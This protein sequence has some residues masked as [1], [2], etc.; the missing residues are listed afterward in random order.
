MSYPS[1]VVLENVASSSGAA[2]YEGRV[3]ARAACLKARTVRI[4][5]VLPDGD[6]PLGED[7]TDADGAFSISAPPVEPGTEVYA[8]VAK[9]VLKKNTRHNHRC[10]ADRSD[11]VAFPGSNTGGSVDLTALPVGDGK[12]SS[13]P[14]TGHLWSCQQTFNPDQGGAGT[15]GPWF[16]GDGTWD[17]TKKVTVSGQVDWPE[18]LQVSVSGNTRSISTNDLPFH[19]TGTFPVAQSDDAYQYD[20]NPNSISAQS[21][22]FALPANPEPATSPA[23]VGG[24]VGVMLS[25]TVIFNAFDAAGRDAVANEVQD[26]CGGHPQNRGVYHYHNVS[27][28]IADEVTGQHSPLFGYAFDGFGIYGYR[29][30]GGKALTNA[31]LDDCHGH[32]HDITWDGQ[33]KSMFH[34]HATHEFPYSIGCYRGTSA[35]KGPL[36]TR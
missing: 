2:S 23:C 22:N 30:E 35:V 12:V 25:G 31:D 26:D 10:K 34:Y 27:A 17:L 28:C 19:L 5:A 29:G 14:K 3:D 6:A 33:T 20:R 7:A 9:K 36:R 8:S 4:F 13:S 11:A 21:F 16:N 18:S 1:T 24:E 32:T 15:Q